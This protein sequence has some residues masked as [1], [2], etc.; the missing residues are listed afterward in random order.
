ML[1]GPLRELRSPQRLG[2]RCED[3]QMERPAVL[4]AGSGNELELG[5]HRFHRTEL[6]LEAGSD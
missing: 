1:G 2:G 4:D 5:D 3:G 6:M